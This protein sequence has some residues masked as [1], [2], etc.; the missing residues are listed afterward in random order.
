MIQMADDEL[1][2]FWAEGGDWIL[3]MGIR[4]IAEPPP[5]QP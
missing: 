3:M 5:S 2:S 4:S 1:D